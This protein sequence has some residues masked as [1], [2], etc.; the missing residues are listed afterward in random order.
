M[1]DNFSFESVY[2]RMLKTN[3]F[4]SFK[5]QELKLWQKQKAKSPEK[6]TAEKSP[7]KNPLKNQQ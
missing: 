4:Y 1:A 6:K 3:D 2:K 5:K 7:S